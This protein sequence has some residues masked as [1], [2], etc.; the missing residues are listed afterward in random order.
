MVVRADAF[1][2]HSAHDSLP[3]SPLVKSILGTHKG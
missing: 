2:L 3:N 1:Q